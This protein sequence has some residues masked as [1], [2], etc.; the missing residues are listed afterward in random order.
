M[1]KH[2]LELLVETCC[3]GKANLATGLTMLTTLALEEV[4]NKQLDNEH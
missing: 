1:V 3:A 4:A 2:I